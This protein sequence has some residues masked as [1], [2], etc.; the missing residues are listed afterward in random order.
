MASGFWVPK[1]VPEVVLAGRVRSQS[2]GVRDMS[3]T[4]SEH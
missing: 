2:L 1:C 3:V 4:I